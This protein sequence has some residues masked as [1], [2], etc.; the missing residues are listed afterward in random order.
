MMLRA[1]TCSGEPH[2][3]SRGRHLSMSCNVCCCPSAKAVSFAT[4]EQG[5]PPSRPLVTQQP[6]WQH[7]CPFRAAPE[8]VAR[9]ARLG[10]PAL[11][12]LAQRLGLAVAR[13]GAG[14]V[15]SSGCTEAPGLHWLVK[16]EGGRPDVWCKVTGRHLNMWPGSPGSVNLRFLAWRSALASPL[17]ASA[18]A[19][20]PPR[21]GY[22]NESR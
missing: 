18:S 6:G 22:A 10:E 3:P 20:R 5:Y 14:A 13:L 15:C 4:W 8:H 19:P 9:L 17:Y 7:P 21:K 16:G 2:A 12:G 11:L 1:R